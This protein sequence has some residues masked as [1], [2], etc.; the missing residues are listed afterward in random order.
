MTVL[1]VPMHA[2]CVYVSLSLSYINE[3]GIDVV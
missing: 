1:L 3:A 2:V